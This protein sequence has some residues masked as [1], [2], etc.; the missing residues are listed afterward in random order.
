M[1]LGWVVGMS[2]CVAGLVVLCCT[3]VMQCCA[4]LLCG[5]RCDSVG[6]Y[7]RLI[8]QHYHLEALFDSYLRNSM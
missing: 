4:V 5:Y 7:D 3:V 1:W 6:V 8:T 2:C